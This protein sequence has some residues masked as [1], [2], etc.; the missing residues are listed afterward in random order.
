MSIL[1]IK[2]IDAERVKY[3]STFAHMLP[4]CKFWWKKCKVYLLEVSIEEVVSNKAELNQSHS[5]IIILL[6]QSIVFPHSLGNTYKIYSYSRKLFPIWASVVKYHPQQ[7]PHS[8]II[9]VICVSSPKLHFWFHHELP[10]WQE[11]WSFA[12]WILTPVL[13]KVCWR[14]RSLIQIKAE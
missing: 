5:L 10:H 1:I 12:Y 13:K 4:N 6:S 14:Y 11:W 2:N 3:S 8:S 9:E 7:R